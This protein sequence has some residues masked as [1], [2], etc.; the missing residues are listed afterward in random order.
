M[1]QKG[2]AHIGL[3]I[4]LLILGFGIIS[5]LSSISKETT[6]TN[7]LLK[8]DECLH[9]PEVKKDLAISHPRDK[10]YI[11]KAIETKDERYCKKIN[12]SG[13]LRISKCKYEV[14]AAKGDPE[15]CSKIGEDIQKNIY[16]NNCYKTIALN[17]VDANVCLHINQEATK[18]LCLSNVGKKALDSS[19]CEMVS[20]DSAFRRECLDFIE[21][22]RF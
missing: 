9:L 15:L 3:I 17:T 12:A 13:E 6:Q 19:I 14:A 10:C 11:N 7:E 22:S 20:P 21:V 16:E 4:I 8:T 5:Y 1:R 2:L 18:N